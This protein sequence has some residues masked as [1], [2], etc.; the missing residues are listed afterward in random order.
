MKA[1]LPQGYGGGGGN[2]ND[3]LRKAQKIQ[4]EAAE[5]QEELN[6]REYS[7]SSGGGMVE[8]TMTGKHELVKLTISPDAV[9]PDDVEMLEDLV[10]AAVNAANRQADSAAAEEMEKITGIMNIPG[11]M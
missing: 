5:K 4:E 9:D 8:A 6:A 10:K 3:M 11:L 2:M 7:A 1:R